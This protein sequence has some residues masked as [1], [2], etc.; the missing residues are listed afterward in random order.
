M[1]MVIWFVRLVWFVGLMICQFSYWEILGKEKG[2]LVEAF[3]MGPLDS[4][5]YYY[6]KLWIMKATVSIVFR[7]DF[8][9]NW[10]I[11][12]TNKL[13]KS[14]VVHRKSEAVKNYTWASCENKLAF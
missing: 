9:F 14:A 7:C 5:Y 12:L 4:Y 11:M 8:F 13:S 2:I 1:F 10:L 6:F 3:V